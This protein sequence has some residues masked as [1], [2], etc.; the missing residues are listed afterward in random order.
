LKGTK[1]DS[2]RWILEDVARR[3]FGIVESTVPAFVYMD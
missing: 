3:D 2:K 1:D